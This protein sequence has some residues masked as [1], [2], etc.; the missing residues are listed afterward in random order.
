MLLRYTDH[1]R[2]RMNQRGITDREINQTLVRYDSITE[3]RGAYVVS[4]KLANKLIHKVVMVEE[5]GQILIL[6]T[7]HR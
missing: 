2:E 7:Y 4:R 3:T 5:N 1:A 6:T